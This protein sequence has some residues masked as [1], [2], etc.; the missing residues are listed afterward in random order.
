MAY[1]YANGLPLSGNADI[2][3]NQAN[4]LYDPRPPV[5]VVTNAAT[6]ASEFRFYL[7]L[8]R[9]RRFDTNGS[10]PVINAIGQRTGLP[11][12]IFGDPEWIGILEHP[13]QPHSGSNRFVARYAF[14]AVPVL[15]PPQGESAPR[16]I[17]EARDSKAIND[18]VPGWV[19][20][21]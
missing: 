12:F 7:D 15:A 5:F 11:H 4:L 9:N 6:G 18:G 16:Q 3:L 21:R 17:A 10:Q 13:D 2:R 20:C 1:T 8:N 14:V 19:M